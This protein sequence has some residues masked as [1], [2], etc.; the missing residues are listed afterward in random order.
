MIRRPPRST[1]F[2]YTTLFRSCGRCYHSAGFLRSAYSQAVS[3]RVSCVFE[4]VIACF[5]DAHELE[6]GM[7]KMLQAMKDFDTQIFRRGDFV[8]KRRHILVERAMIEFFE[9]MAF[10]K[11]VQIR[12]IG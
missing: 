12:E 2:P 7:W 6:L 4:A 10:D 8:A 3:L 5:L 1:L 9:D 11:G